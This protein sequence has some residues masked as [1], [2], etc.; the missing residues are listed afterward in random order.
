MQTVK[1]EFA[2]AKLFSGQSMNFAKLKRK[3][4][5]T[6]YSAD[7]AD[8]GRARGATASN[9][10]IGS[11]NSMDRI[12]FNSSR[13]ALLRA[14]GCPRFKANRSFFGTG[15]QYSRRCSPLE[16]KPSNR[17]NCQSDTLSPYLSLSCAGSFSG[18]A[19]VAADSRQLSLGM[20]RVSEVAAATTCGSE[21]ASVSRM[22]S[23]PQRLPSRKNNV[24]RSAQRAA[25][26]LDYFPNRESKYYDSDLP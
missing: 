11:T 26:R 1:A 2:L 13:C 22:K 25:T 17:A 23:S 15:I 6:S 14:G 10:A 12:R 24:R 8:C 7:C 4:A 19:L 5:F 16:L 3:A 18:S 9:D 20:L 21:H